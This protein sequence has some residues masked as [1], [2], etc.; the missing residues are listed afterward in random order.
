MSQPS[1]V[2]EF[3]FMF[4]FKLLNGNEPLPKQTAAEFW[5]SLLIRHD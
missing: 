4:A 1:N 5:V 3:L 2:L